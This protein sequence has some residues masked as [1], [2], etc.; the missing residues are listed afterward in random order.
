[1]LNHH[2]QIVGLTVV[3]PP[4]SG[5]DQTQ[6]LRRIA[7][8]DQ[9]AMAEF[10]RLHGRIVLA[11]ILLVVGERA[12]GEEILQDTMLAIWRGADSFLGES[13]VRSWVIAI[14]RRQARDR[15]RRH[16]IAV[17]DDALLAEQ[18]SAEPGPEL[19]AL[20]RAEVAAVASAIRLLAPRHREVLG[21]A[22]GAGLSLPEVADVLQVPLGTVKSRLA[23]ARTALA[24]V[25]HEKGQ[26]R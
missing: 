23:A 1:L 24:R 11:Q 7:R 18:P 14:A 8:G 12:L 21:L 4:D 25:L 16:R 6:L 26:D 22:F 15:L 20:E 2:R 13:A 19:V 9:G 17:V 10:Y 5:V 3:G